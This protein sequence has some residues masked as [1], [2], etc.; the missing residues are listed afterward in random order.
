MRVPSIQMLPQ[1]KTIRT[2]KSTAD[3]ECLNC[4]TIHTVERDTDG[5]HL[6]Q[7]PCHMDECT[8]HLCEWC[9]QFECTSCGLSHCSL[10]R[11]RIGA[12]E[13]CSTCILG[14]VDSAVAEY[15]AFEGDADLRVQYEPP[16][17]PTTC[18]DWCAW[19]DGQ[20]E[21]GSGY[22]PTRQAAIENLL[23]VLA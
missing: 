5:A 23:E 21:R 6:D 20:E 7:V 13:F 1:Q 19:M 2:A 10:H 15:R 16:P 17:I 11:V 18:S 9:P 14:Y 8:R 3:V 4:S 22:G 12:E